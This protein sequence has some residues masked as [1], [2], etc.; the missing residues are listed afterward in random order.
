MA[1]RAASVG[2]KG[3][4]GSVAAVVC[5][6]QAAAA[7]CFGVALHS[8]R[9][10][11]RGSA[12]QSRAR[13]VSVYLARIAFDICL[14]DIARNTGRDG[15][16]IRHSCAVV[17]DMRDCP[18]ADFALAILEHAFRSSVTLAWINQTGAL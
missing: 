13:H 9:Q 1:N 8:M 2:R 5:A 14:R 11:G 12:R 17:E 16:T 6:A 3:V 7:A 4:P 10:A 15:A 18:R